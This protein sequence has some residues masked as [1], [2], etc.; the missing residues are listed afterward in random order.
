MHLFLLARI[1]QGYIILKFIRLKKSEIPIYEVRGRIKLSNRLNFTSA[2]SAYF[3]LARKVRGKLKL[4]DVL[5]MYSDS[6]PQEL[7]LW[8]KCQSAEFQQ[9]DAGFSLNRPG[10]WAVVTSINSTLSQ[11]STAT[12]GI[13]S[14]PF[15]FYLAWLLPSVYTVFLLARC[16]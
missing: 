16:I 12:F 15:L 1:F 9:P 6:W 5:L 11:L 10:W 4:S 3:L 13:W 2:R 7:F 14:C 8:F